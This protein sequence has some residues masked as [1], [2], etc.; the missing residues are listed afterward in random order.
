MKLLFSQFHLKEVFKQLKDLQ[1][2][3][4]EL[5]FAYICALNVLKRH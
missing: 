1:G 5:I 2:E 4:N 3:K